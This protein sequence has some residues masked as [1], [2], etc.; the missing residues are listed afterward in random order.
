MGNIDY[1][2]TLYGYFGMLGL[3]GIYNYGLRE[4]SANRNKTG[5]VKTIYKNLFFIGLFTN[6]L[7][8]TLYIIFVYFFIQDP[9]LKKIA[10][11]LC[12]NLISQMIYVEWYNEAM[13]EFRFITIKTVGIRL[14]SF[15][16]IFTLVRNETDEYKY[17][18]IT[19]LVA[20]INYLV[21]YI[22]SR[23][24]I[25]ISVKELF[26]DL[27]PSRYIVPLLTILIL[28]NTGYL[29]TVFDRTM[30]GHFTGT[31]SVAYFSLGQKIVE[32]CKLVILSV[33]FATLPRLALYLNENPEL[34]KS[35]LKRIMSLTMCLMIPVSIGLLMLAEPIILIFGG[36]EYIPA[37][38]PMRIFA[39]RIII[40]GIDAILY[41][42]VIFLH[43][44]EKILVGYN[45]LCGGI[46]IALNLIFL[47]ILTPEISI[48]CTLASEI[49]F[50]VI[51][52]VYIHKKFRINVGL[53]NLQCLRY[54]ILS[55][56]FIPI[57]L[58][59]QT[60]GMNYIYL[61][62]TTM[63][64]CMLFYIG[65]LTLFKDSNM[66]YL[67]SFIQKLIKR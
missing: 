63:A 35:T 34:Y 6:I 28:N 5:L 3:S 49:I 41:N 48:L 23:R 54:L 24:K 59:L 25:K 17:V 62:V 51:C 7:F 32:L 45:L 9:E 27:H 46:N 20:V 47:K 13:E 29:Y 40:L 53:F 61:S 15:I 2:N 38:S 55:L 8:L 56:L 42:E 36:H 12:G 14:C 4:I 21:S 50:V 31:E 58:L 33:V 67:M 64:G 22:Y 37:I 66:L 19:V 10:Y 18:I 44:K 39:L 16:F 52:L 11:I 30:L 1:A 43:G 57:I 65:V 26:K 60:T